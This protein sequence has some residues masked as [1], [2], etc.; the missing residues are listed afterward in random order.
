MRKGFSK[1]KAT[2]STEKSEGW[3]LG[4]NV[5]AQFIG[6]TVSSILFFAFTS[7]FRKSLIF[8]VC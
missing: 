2:L 1:Q 7:A 3:L 8:P 4:C 6:R 5:S